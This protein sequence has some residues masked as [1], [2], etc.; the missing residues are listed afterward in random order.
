[1]HEVPLV[2][3]LVTHRRRL[4][5]A[6]D[7]QAFRRA[8][9]VRGGIEVVDV[10]VDCLHRH[11]RVAKIRGVCPRRHRLSH[12]YEFRAV[13]RGPIWLRPQRHRGSGWRDV[14]LGQGGGRSSD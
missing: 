12:A 11:S 9:E 14:F 7:Q 8:E 4:V 2:H 5:G 3:M 6:V 13:G 1:M 10:M